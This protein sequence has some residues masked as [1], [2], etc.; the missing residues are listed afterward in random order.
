[1]VR[2]LLNS[3]GQAEDWLAVAGFEDKR[4][5]ADD[6]PGSASVA[7]RAPQAITEFPGVRPKQARRDCRFVAIGAVLTRLLL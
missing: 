4:N 7:T 1:M 5:D 6:P 3:P 2:G